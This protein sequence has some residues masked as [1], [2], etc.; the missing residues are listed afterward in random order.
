MVV[1]LN[2]DR[3]Y[4]EELDF[5]VIH[6]KIHVSL[7]VFFHLIDMSFFISYLLTGGSEQT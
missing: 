7:V 2:D 3:A 4:S 6:G 5:M 1:P